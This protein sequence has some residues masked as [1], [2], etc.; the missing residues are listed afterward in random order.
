MMLRRF[1]CLSLN[2]ELISSISRTLFEIHSAKSCKIIE[3]K[4]NSFDTNTE[5]IVNA[6][7][8]A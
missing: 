8:A 3:L 4:I 1:E 5:L 2:S 6:T 7:S